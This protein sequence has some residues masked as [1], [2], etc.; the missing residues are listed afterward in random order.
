MLVVEEK[1]DLGAEVLQEPRLSVLFQ[2][3]L[4]APQ[5]EQALRCVPGKLA[6]LDGL[7]VHLQRVVGWTEFVA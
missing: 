6:I 2:H 3:L 7:V 4:L 5:P 1:A